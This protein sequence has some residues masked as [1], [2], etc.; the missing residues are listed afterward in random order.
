MGGGNRMS[1]L[2]RPQHDWDDF[3]EDARKPKKRW[4][5]SRILLI[6]AAI[7]FAATVIIYYYRQ[8]QGG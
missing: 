7:A 1:V 3:L 4:R 6:V 8:Y 2:G 5:L